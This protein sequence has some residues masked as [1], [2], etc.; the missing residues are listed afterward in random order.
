MIFGSLFKKNTVQLIYYYYSWANFENLQIRED[1]LDH[2]C[3]WFLQVFFFF[4]RL[5]TKH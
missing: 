4:K 5:C 1:I 2:S 3:P